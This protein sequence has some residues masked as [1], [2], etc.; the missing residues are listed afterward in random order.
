M[1][2]SSALLLSATLSITAA[3]LVATAAFL[4]G[5]RLGPWQWLFYAG[6]LLT[7]LAALYPFRQA[8]W[9]SRRWMRSLLGRTSPTPDGESEPDE[10]PVLPNEIASIFEERLRQVE[11][12][13]RELADRLAGYHQWFEFPPP[14]DL[15]EIKPASP[16]ILERDRK[17][18]QLLEE[19]TKDLYEKI[20][21]NEYSPEGTFHLTLV[22]EDVYALVGEIAALYG[23]DPDHPLAGVSSERVLRAAGRCCLKFL[24]ELEKLPLGIRNYDIVDIY[25]YVRQAVNVYGLY[26][27]ARPYMPWVRGAY[28][29][30]WVAMGANPLALG[31]WWFVSALGTKGASTVATNIANR[32][33]LSFL[34]DLVR[35]IGYE[36]AGIYDQNLRY[37]DPNWCFAAELIELVQSFPSSEQ[38][39][40]RSL[41]LIGA[42][43]LQNEYDRI[44][45]F[46]CIVEGKKAGLKRSQAADLL[47]EQQREIAERLEAFLESNISA[48][49]PKIVQR[50]RAGVEDRLDIALTLHDPV[51][52]RPENEQRRDA[53]RAL[54]GFLLEIKQVE[55]D[56]LRPLLE[57]TTIA[58]AIPEQ[59]RPN[60]WQSL[61]DNPPFFF[62]MPEIAPAGPVAHEFL[63]DLVVLAARVT[64]RYPV[65]DEIVVATAVRL[66]TDGA[67]VK[68]H[69]D[70]EYVEEL[71]RHLPEDAP[72][73]RLAPGVARAVLD[74]AQDN[75]QLRFVYADVQPVDLEHNELPHVERTKTWLVGVGDRLVAFTMTDVPELIWE[76]DATT[77]CEYLHGRFR[78]NC[79]LTGGRWL[80]Q[81]TDATPTIFLR[82]PGFGRSKRHFRPLINFC[83][84]SITS[85][86]HSEIQ[87]IPKSS[88]PPPQ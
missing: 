37:R 23:D 55:Q 8:T 33:A 54:A 4:L 35:V 34:H 31:A 40:R 45:F 17:L 36:V 87:T 29:G 66:R 80:T 19:R 75:E 61:D 68:K 9:G 1:R 73:R 30:T 62:Q 77:T 46:R 51:A 53:L 5:G 16:H 67:K 6:S 39:F 49:D 3:I 71:A 24:V 74:L 60:L 20:R 85:K 58:V 76:G 18:D 86:V 14:L 44:F 32:W 10:L 2:Q 69:L 79:R 15:A 57:S 82:G 84:Q 27:S 56:T 83:K 21:K 47:P 63:K 78:S 72:N 50:W 38:S 11:R 26:R 13:E 12:R 52:A 41:S 42:L 22:R 25:A 70:A 28:Y 81:A 88:P 7:V 48:P 64:P 59:E 43:Q 65:A